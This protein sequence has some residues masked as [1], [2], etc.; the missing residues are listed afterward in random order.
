MGGRGENDYEMESGGVLYSCSVRGLSCE[1]SVVMV[2][3][4]IQNSFDAVA[5][6]EVSE[7]CICTFCVLP[8]PT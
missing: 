6:S 5:E 1:D 4:T 3:P 8:Y 2:F 7:L